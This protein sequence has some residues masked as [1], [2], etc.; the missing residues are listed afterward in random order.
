M[1]DFFGPWKSLL[2]TRVFHDFN[3]KKRQEHPRSHGSSQMD[4][5]VHLHDLR[6][7]QS[8]KFG[9]PWQVKGYGGFLKWWYPQ[10]PHPK[11]IIFRRKTHGFVGETHHFRKPPYTKSAGKL[12]FI[13]FVSVCWTILVLF[14]LC[15]SIMIDHIRQNICVQKE[16]FG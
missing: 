8:I 3:A 14:Y 4:V 9:G 11:M 5:I 6:K 1:D 2:K 15:I 12:S 7:P 16:V 10:S 13:D